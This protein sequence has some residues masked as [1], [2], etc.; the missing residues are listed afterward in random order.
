MRNQRRKNRWE[1]LAEVEGLRI[2]GGKDKTTQSEKSEAKSE[3]R[4]KYGKAGRGPVYEVTI[5]LKDWNSRI[6]GRKMS[7]QENHTNDVEKGAVENG[8]GSHDGEHSK[9][10][11]HVRT[12]DKSNEEIVIPKNRLILVFIGLMLTVFLAA[13]DMT[14]VGTSPPA[15]GLTRCAATALPTIVRDLGGGQ[16]Y[17]WI[18]TSYLLASASLTPLY[19]RCRF[20]T[21]RGV[22]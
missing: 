3:L 10:K 22:S 20:Q 8:N 21:F 12:G 1:N 17:A 18:G 19:G 14:I 9:G 11:G 13:L 7:M 5:V 2:K 15:S 6:P 16:N 4:A